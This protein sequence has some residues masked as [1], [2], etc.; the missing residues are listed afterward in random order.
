VVIQFGA[1]AQAGKLD[2]FNSCLLQLARLARTPG[3]E[4]FVA[5][6]LRSFAPLVPFAS[7][8]WG[9]MSNAD[10]N[11]APQS[12][13]HGRINLPESF[14]REWN[15]VA[16]RD[17]FAHS[18]LSHPGEL[19]RASGFTDPCAAVNAFARRHDLYHLMCIT[20]ELPESGLMFFVCLYRGA[21]EAAFDDRESRLFSA[22]CDHLL[23]LWRFQLQD[24]LQVDSAVGALDF[25][26]ARTDGTLLYVGSGLCAALVHESP[27]WTGSVLPASVTAQ[28]QQLPC[29]MRLGRAALTLSLNG[30]YVILSLNS[31]SRSSGLPP[32]ERTA[33]MLF[34]AGHSYKEIA[35]ILLL[36]P[37]TVRTYL[38]NSYQQL[39]VSS[40]VELGYALRMSPTS[41]PVEQRN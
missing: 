28:L 10:S 40:K 31:H 25:A 27:E 17:R 37:A 32:R 13:M 2:A 41:A 38:R 22:F 5:R 35:K 18:T 12:W 30:E 21:T 33:A 20:F 7:A 26:V 6:A 11:T 14:A 39:G 4:T 3:A 19:V 9:E 1:S 16:A 36:T 15:Q 29:V 8:W 24:L 34:A 23:Q